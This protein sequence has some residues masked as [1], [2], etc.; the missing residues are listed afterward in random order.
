MPRLAANLSWLFQEWAFLDRFSAAADAGF[1]AV[2][3]LFPY[4]IAPDGIAA[5]LAQHKLEQVLFNAAPGDFANGERGLAALPG[6]GADFRAAFATALD[7]AKATATP[8]LHVMAGIASG[9]EALDSYK[10]AL[11]H[12]CEAAPHLDILI[13]PINSK[14]I[15][16]YLMNS[17]EL[18]AAIIAELKLPNLK[19]QF[20]IYHRQMMGQPLL[21]GLEEMLP[22]TGHVQVASPPLRAEPGDVE[23]DALNELDA[24]GYDG[25]VGCEYRPANGTLAGLDWISLL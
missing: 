13:E 7:Y 12:A 4:D 11:R 2:E 15:P 17:F 6:R 1:T 5:K 19:L 3:Y 18:A 16:G 9:P 25:W 22:I 20:D 23:R 8:R 14:D 21:A 24:L 10:D